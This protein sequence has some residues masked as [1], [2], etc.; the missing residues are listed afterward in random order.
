MHLV[1]CVIPFWQAAGFCCGVKLPNSMYVLA[2][3][4]ALSSLDRSSA[5]SLMQTNVKGLEKFSL[6]FWEP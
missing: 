1:A 3:A 5:V 6:L 2:L 4:D